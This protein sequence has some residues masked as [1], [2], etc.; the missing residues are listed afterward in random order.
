[1]Q[2][3]NYLCSCENDVNIVLGRLDGK[4]ADPGKIMES[5]MSENLLVFSPQAGNRA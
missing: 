4:Y 3:I 1:M 5:I 2:C